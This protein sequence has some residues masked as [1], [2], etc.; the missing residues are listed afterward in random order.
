MFKSHEQT[1]GQNYNLKIGSKCFEMVVTVQVFGNNSHQSR[2][3]SGRNYE[4]I[5]A[6]NACYDMVHTILS[7]SLR[8]K[9]IKITIYIVIIC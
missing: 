8:A 9:N 5:E 2:L 6:G 3:Y 7:S 4:Q 1:A